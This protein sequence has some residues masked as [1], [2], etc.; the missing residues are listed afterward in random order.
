MLCVGML[1]VDARSLVAGPGWP[2]DVHVRLH[3]QIPSVQIAC[4][5]SLVRRYFEL[6]L[7]TNSTCSWCPQCNWDWAPLGALILYIA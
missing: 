5:P 7:H 3:K 1:H 4:I 2:K 6:I